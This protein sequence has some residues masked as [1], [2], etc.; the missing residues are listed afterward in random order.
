MYR[1]VYEIKKL[2]K[3]PPRALGFVKITGQGCGKEGNFLINP[4]LEESLWSYM[5]D[6]PIIYQII[7]KDML[8]NL[9]LGIIN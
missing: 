4:V 2:R 6:K 9:I 7:K 5:F 3:L 1:W 8:L